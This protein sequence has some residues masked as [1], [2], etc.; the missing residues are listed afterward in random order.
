M[1]IASHLGAVARRVE[2]RTVEG[3][4]A[5]VV[6]ASRYYATT[7]EDLWDALTSKERLPRWFA[8]V[9]GDL[10]L[11]GKYQVKGNAG[12][13]VTACTPPRSFSLTWE[14]GGQVS[15]VNVMLAP[16][17]PGE[18]HLTLEHIAHINDHW[19]KFGPGAV[20]IGWELGLM[21]LAWHI[22]GR[23]REGFDEAAWGAS[24]DGKTFMRG[25]G[26]GWIEADIRSG[27]NKADAITR[28][29]ST[30]SF[31]LGEPPPGTAHPGTTKS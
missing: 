31:Y 19:K 21:G 13:T 25:S 29:Q 1:D 20:G 9:E 4:P 16:T 30:I 28:G 26:E 23:S 18:A 14:F 11:G 2:N 22:A 7:I 27:E 10:Q 6:I 5:R 15:W 3:K 12:G 24:P 8:P 17:R